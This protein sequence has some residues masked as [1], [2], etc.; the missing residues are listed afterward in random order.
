MRRGK[1]VYFIGIGKIDK[2]GETLWLAIRYI[3]NLKIVME[4]RGISFADVLK[5]RSK[6]TTTQ[7]QK[8]PPMLMEF[9]LK[10]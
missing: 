9:F 1:A 2:I 10:F 4:A 5:N 8:P 6:S 7:Q 3:L